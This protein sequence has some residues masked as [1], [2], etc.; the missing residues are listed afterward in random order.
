[1]DILA[2]RDSIVSTVKFGNKDFFGH[3]NQEKMTSYQS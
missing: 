1:M 3:H 2:E